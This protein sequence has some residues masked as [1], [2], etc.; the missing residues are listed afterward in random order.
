MA[1][2]QPQYTNRLAGEKSP[3]LLQHAHNPVDWYPWGDEALQEAKAQDRPIFLSIGYAT[4]HWCH[5]MERESFENAAIAREMNDLFI[6]IKVDREEL[7]EIDAL[8]MEFAQSMMSGAAGWPLNVILTPDLLP[9]FAAT[10]MPPTSGRGLMGMD[11]LIKRIREVWLGPERER[12]SEQ[13][14]RIVEVFAETVHTMGT[15]LPFKEQ[16]LLAAELFFK[17]ADPI[18]GGMKGSPKFPIGYQANFLLTYSAQTKDGRALFLVQR[19]LDMMQRGGIRDHL[20]GGFGRYSVDEKWLVPHFEKMLYDNA[21]LADAYLKLWQVNKEP[22]FREVAEEVLDYILRDLT[23][24]DGGFFSAEDADSQGVEGLFYTWTMQEI[25]NILQPK[26]A[27]I[28]CD[29]YGITEKGDFEGRNVLHIVIPF[30]EF[31]LGQGV[32]PDPL[33]KKLSEMRKLLWNVREGRPR[34]FKDDKILAGWNGLTIYALVEAGCAFGQERYLLAAERAAQFIRSEMRREKRLFRRWRDGQALFHANLDDYAF[35]IRGLLSLFESGRGL[36][37]LEWALELTQ[38]LE[39]D[40]KAEDGAFYQTDGQDPTLLLR[41]VHYPDGAEPSGNAVH[42]ENLL[43][44]YQLT[45]ERHYLEQAE[46]V[47]RAVKRFI[48]NYAP[49]YTYH[50]MN[51]ARYYDRAA[52]L[53]IVALNEVDEGRDEIY[54]AI[55]DRFNPFK[56]LVWRKPTDSRLI[57]LIPSLASQTAKDGKTTVYVCREGVCKEPLNDLP[58]IIEAL[59]KL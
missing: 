29:Y 3:Y 17:M 16:V 15:Q 47:M 35:L 18:Y 5:V 4:C 46:D 22:V 24:S 1:D 33:R 31:A 37:W 56:F 7:P 58:N 11:A 19:T 14:A 23:H 50:L 55:F 30:E 8:Y 57:D 53:V 27:E 6:N 49:G 34:P 10:Y 48:D 28:F 9:F 42:T 41:K 2:D 39:E 40:F 20:G 51:I 25:K 44:L 36:E 59:N 26:D 21:L 52:P 13:A 45:H 43:R 54:A 32:D 38:V 12:V